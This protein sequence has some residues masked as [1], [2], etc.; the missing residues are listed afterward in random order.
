V[1]E[2]QIVNFLLMLVGIGVVFAFILFNA[3]YLTYAERKIIGHMQA[4]LGPMRTGWHGIL[5]PIAD[6]LKL[7][8]KEDII[9]TQADKPVFILAPFMALIPAFAGFV[10]VPFGPEITLFGKTFP[11]Y[12]TDLNIGVL[13]ILA[14]SGVGVYGILMAG[15]ASN[16][17]YSLLGGLR[18]A[19]QLISYEMAMGLAIVSVVLWS[20]SLSLVS[21]VNAQSHFWF[22]LVQPV[23]FFIFVVSMLAETNRAPF[24]LP[25]AETELVS[26]FH[27]EYSGMRFAFF[28]M[29]EYANMVIVSIMATVLFLGGWHA[30]FGFLSFVPPVLWFLIKVYFLLFIFIWVRATLP[31]YRFDQLMHLGWKVFLPI[32]LVNV[33]VTA[34]ILLWVR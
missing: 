5:Q 28:F 25:E 27:T 30:P 14:L 17:K 31:R 7:F 10:I 20:G 23:A 26:G 34:L 24:D 11:L 4:R 22:V 15:W 16:S 29:A 32:G 12:V 21:I 9:P 19:A 33:L 8:F 1:P 6:G 13:F 2:S 3:A 18:S